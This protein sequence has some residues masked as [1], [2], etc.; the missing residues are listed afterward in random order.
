MLREGDQLK[1]NDLFYGLLLPSGNDSAVALA[2][3]F[4]YSFY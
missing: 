1:L 2:T 3:Y 4:G